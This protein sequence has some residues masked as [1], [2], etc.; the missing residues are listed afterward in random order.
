M[1]KDVVTT[2]A[3]TVTEEASN[4]AGFYAFD[5]AEELGLNFSKTF[6]QQ[7]VMRRDPDFALTNFRRARLGDWTL[8]TGSR[9]PVA[10]AHLEDAG[11]H[12]AFMGKGVDAEGALIDH[13]V[14]QSKLE[15][16]RDPQ[17]LADDLNECGGRFVFII[18]GPDFERL[19]IDPSGIMGAVYNQKAGFVAA[20][21]H[22]AIDR[23][24]EPTTEY[25]AAQIALDGSGGRFAF[26]FTP[27]RDVKRVLANHYLDL[28]DFSLTRHWP[29]PE[30]DFTCPMREDVI[31]ARLYD[32]IA[33][34][35]VIMNA[36]IRG[37]SPAILPIT[38]GADSRLLLAFAKD[39]LDDVDLFFTHKTNF[40]TG[41]DME[42]A[43]LLAKRVGV[44]L[45]KFDLMENPDLVRPQR[46]CQR[47]H[48]QEKLAEGLFDDGPT[49]DRKKISERM[50]LPPGGV[51]LRGHVTDISKAVLWQKI[52]VREF[53]RKNGA[54]HDP[55]VGLRLLKTGE[56]AFE[57]P[58]YHEKYN[59]WMDTLPDNARRRAVD[60]MALEQFRCHGLGAQFYAFTH[61]FY[62]APGSD[63]RIIQALVS[64]PPH[65]R[66]EYHINDMLLEQCAPELLDVPYTRHQDNDLRQ[67][68]RKFNKLL[69]QGP[70]VM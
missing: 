20:T 45:T 48:R 7:F 37:N 34:H 10:Q 4:P 15:R 26:G 6:S 67:T 19:Y 47:M 63:R 23:P 18:T 60:F 40:N 39:A 14:L 32:V 51:L 22:L 55:D 56:D 5:R 68:R 64:I 57:N 12:V 53:E 21:V 36:L 1:A 2:T 41:R 61:N 58:W 35:K 49:P 9:M 42:L 65:L 16:L 44:K 59:A 69:A 29:R 52:G 50:I 43:G 27:D 62:M 66:S 17:A 24:V 33:R 8:L 46:M 30:D 38:G 3:T 25:P 13:R 11:L 54:H 70:E 31:R 28:N